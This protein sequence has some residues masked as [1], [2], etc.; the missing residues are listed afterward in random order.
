M[1]FVAL[2]LPPGV[3]RRGT[4]YET[5]GRWYDSHLMR[6]KDGAMGPIGG[7]A[8][9]LTT[10]MSGKCRALIT[11]RDNSTT[12]WI[13]AGTHTKLYAGTQSV[14]ALS[15]ITPVGLTTGSADASAAGGYGS[16]DYGEGLY[17][18]PRLDSSATQDASV[19][20]LDTFG[21]NLLA[22]LSEDGRIFEWT[23]N[24]GVPAAALAG[25]PVSNRG[26]VVTP[27]RF[28]FALGA[29]G[30]KRKVQWADQE[31]TTVWTPSAT[32]QA[33]DLIL[34]TQG[35]LMCG[36]RLRGITLLFTDQDVHVAQYIG[37]PFV[38]AIQPAGSNCGVISRGAVAAVDTRAFW[39]GKKGF[40]VCDGA[41][42][43]PVPCDVYDAVFNDMNVTQASKVTAL[44]FSG[45]NEVWWFYPSASSTENDRAVCYNYLEGHW[46]LHQFSRLAG[47]D[48]GVF[49]NPIM[50][51]SSGYLWDHESGF[52]YSGAVSPYA[53]AGPLELGA[54]DRIAKV[55]EMIPDEKT[56][57]DVQATF[58]GRDAPN[59]AE[60]TFGPYTMDEFTQVRFAAR[61]AKLR[62]TG[63]VATS[64]RWGTPRLDVVAGGRR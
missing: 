39:M 8:Q 45:E 1:T 61:Q 36:K 31:S 7:W 47:A 48:R 32:N 52:T 5:Q 21:Q 62:V 22:C 6:W 18:T 59:G 12:R 41:L 16:L 49:N 17:G 40:F 30:D 11:W 25:A 56:Q 60:T 37:L 13:A 19:W 38:Y 51:D 33:G 34:Q 24:I 64:W 23:L 4:Q 26:V 57:G 10:P 58:Y 43:Q 55:R 9:R 44:A 29:G 53:E 35:Q 2:D 46:Q 42:T 63:A 20:T 28:V 3:V 15:D 14:A 54:G 27:E 50:A